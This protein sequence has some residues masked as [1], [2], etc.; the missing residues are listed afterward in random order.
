MTASRA[1]DLDLGEGYYGWKA[2]WAPDR[3]LNPQYEGIPDHP[4][5]ALILKCGP[6]GEEGSVRLARGL[7][8]EEPPVW[9]VVQEQPLTLSPS[10]SAPC[11]C[12]GFI[13]DG[14]WVPA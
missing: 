1:A 2:G 11:G 14:K 8:G 3:D 6:H 4:F 10:V 9:A 13:H 12:H 5:V 7:P